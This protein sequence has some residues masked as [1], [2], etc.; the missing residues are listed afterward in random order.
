M[1]VH[2][3]LQ[4]HLSQFLQVLADHARVVV[5]VKVG[6]GQ[7]KFRNL[8]EVSTEDVALEYLRTMVPPKKYFF[9]PEEVALSLLHRNR[10]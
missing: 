8:N 5:P 4:A 6:K 3:L 9:P 10:L 2:F 7:Y 1:E